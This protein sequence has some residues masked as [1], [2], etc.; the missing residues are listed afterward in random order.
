MKFKYKAIQKDGQVVQDEIEALNMKMA[1]SALSAR[2]LKPLSLKPVKKAAFGSA[3]FKKKI[4]LEDKVFLTRYL[5]LMLRVGT[6][7]FK[8]ID[9]LIEDFDKPAVR[10]LL[11]E[12][13]SNL[14]QGKPFYI[15]FENHKRDFSPVF[16]NLIK[17][18]EASGNLEE[19][20]EQVS[21]SLEG[22]HELEQKI[23]SSLTYPI[24]L[25][26]A[27]V[28]VLILM[29]SFSLPKVAKVFLSGGIEPPGFSKIVFSIG[30]FVG[31]HLTFILSFLV[32]GV[33]SI[34]LF[35]LKTLVGKRLLYDMGLRVPVINR[36]IKQT[37]LQR[38]ASTLSSLLRSGLS[39]T[40]A[41]DITAGSVGMP[42][43]K[44]ALHR[45]NDEGIKKGLTVGE[46]FHRE[47]I[48]PKVV[49]NLIAVS[50]KSGN[51]EK[52]LNTLS[53]FYASEIG[54]AVKSLVSFIE[55]IMLLFIGLVIGTIALAVIIPVYQLSSSF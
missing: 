22:Q 8:A 38:F 4:T 46:A 13:R 21:S 3:L 20:F 2:S 26:I 27:S 37:S 18:G 30:L 33:V 9:I 48:F 24:I 39:I 51:I 31:D 54:S 43:I 23:K 41:L 49:S 44:D 35:F 7:L 5:A 25:M 29:V 6:D 50:E 19:V 17:A 10:S 15:T 42:A 36:I 52:I 55:P 1:L 45:I 12:I 32:I 16:V 34:L 40:E 47:P 28:L 53:E 11:M 14:E